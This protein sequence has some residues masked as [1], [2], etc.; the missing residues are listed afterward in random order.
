MELKEIVVLTKENYIRTSSPAITM[1]EVY[2]SV[3]LIELEPVAMHVTCVLFSLPFAL[4]ER[5]ERVELLL[6]N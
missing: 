6:V 5:V 1:C 2:L 4:V 3:S